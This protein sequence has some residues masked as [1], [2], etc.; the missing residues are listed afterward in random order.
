MD[1]II[2]SNVVVDIVLIAIICFGFIYGARFGVVKVIA[3]PFK[4]LSSFVIASVAAV[5]LSTSVVLPAIKEP[6]L[7]KCSEQI[8]KM[9]ADKDEVPLFF[10]MIGITK[11]TLATDSVE[12]ISNILEPVFLILSVIITFF[13]AYLLGKLLLSIA[14]G[15]LNLILNIGFLKY[16]S[17]V[18]GAVLGLLVFF[19]I[20]TVVA[21]VFG[22]LVKLDLLKDVKFFAEF[23]GGF[24]Y[25]AIKS[26]WTL[27]FGF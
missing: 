6:L 24:V 14:F 18:L 16:I 15:L 25:D 10:R 5:S 17:R 8:I 19:V 2:W 12:I 27:F 13:V 1:S 11:E 21:N 26:A 22:F 7:G 23:T 3:K 20:A 9:C 4:L